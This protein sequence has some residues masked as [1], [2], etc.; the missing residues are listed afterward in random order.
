MYTAFC[1]VVSLFVLWRR[2]VAFVQAVAMSA[3][4]SPAAAGAITFK[5]GD[6]TVIFQ[7]LS[8]VGQGYGWQRITSLRNRLHLLDTTI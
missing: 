8:K 6:P 3:A 7:I 1:F 4:K 5:S 2:R